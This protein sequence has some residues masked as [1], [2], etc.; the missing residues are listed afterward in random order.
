MIWTDA[1]WQSIYATGQDVL[2]A[3]A[4]GSGKTA[5]LV[6]RIIQKILRDGIDVDRLLV[7]TFTNL[8]AREMKH[9]VDQRIQEASIADPA[10]AHL[11]NQRIKIHQAQISTLHSFCLKLIQQHYDVLNIDPNFRT[12]SEAENILLLE[13][14]IDEVIEQ[15]Y[16]ILDPAF[17]ELTEQLSSDRSDDQFRMIIKQLYFFSV[18]N[19]NPTNWLDQLVT[20]Y[21]EEAQQAQLIQL[22]TDLSKVFITAAYDALNKAYDLF[23][24]MDSVDK[25]LAVI[26]DERRL[27]GR[28]LEG[29]F[30]DIPYLTGHEF[31]ARL[32]NVTAKIKEANE[33]MVDALEDAKLQYKK[34]KSLIDKVKSDYFSREADDLKADMQQLAP[35]VKY[36]ARIVKDVMSEFNRKK[37]SKNI[38]DFSDYEHFALQILT[39]EDGSPSEIAESYRQ[40]FQ[41]ILVDEYQDT[42][43][44]QEKILSCIKTG[45]EHNGNLFMVGDV[46][47][48]I[49]KFR[50][51]DPSL[52]IE[53]YQR[54]TIDGDGTGRRIDLSQNFRSRKEVLST[55]NYIFK[56]MMDE[57]VGEVKYDEAA[58]LYYGAPYD[59][60]DH[61]V[62]LKVL[63]EADQEHSD[64]T[65]SEQEAHFI[66]EQVKDI[67]EHQKVYDMKTG[68]YRSAT[69]KDI[70]ILRTQLWTSSQFTTSL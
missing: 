39:N 63:V 54:F 6:E 14:T 23:S 7:V 26:E 67:L 65:G 42:N 44:V 17:I 48:S 38:L 29:G 30:I 2:V 5:V 56:H 53:K 36:L 27:M 13:Q 16:D 49:Y 19:P 46:K 40:H 24:M 4:A 70:V 50:Q 68:S 57:Q 9:R 21:E 34:Y 35:R 8:S 51:A 22:L 28:V 1:Q 61:P 31:G 33:M 64:L 11:K 12:S 60:S 41:E 58:Q 69:Y 45:D 15:H 52:F 10:N 47:Q 18:A 20:P 25:H 66:V 59:E 43:R 55:T 3:A 37:R 62:N 32:P